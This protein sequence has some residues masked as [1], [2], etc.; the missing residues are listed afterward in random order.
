[1]K[2]HGFDDYA[3]IEGI[4]DTPEP[5]FQAAAATVRRFAVSDEEAVMLLDMVSPKMFRC[6]G[7]SVH[8]STDGAADCPGGPACDRE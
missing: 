1:M 2:S 5:I 7:G 6:V 8:R 3:P 4:P